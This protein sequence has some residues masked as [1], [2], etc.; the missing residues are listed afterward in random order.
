M[1]QKRKRGRPKLGKEKKHLIQVFVKAKHYAAAKK[2]IKK[3][4]GVYN[5]EEDKIAV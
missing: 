3:I 2:E 1:L 4:A 5:T